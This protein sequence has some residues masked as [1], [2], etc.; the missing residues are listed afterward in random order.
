MSGVNDRMEKDDIFDHFRTEDVFTYWRRMESYIQMIAQAEGAKAY[1]FLQ[2]INMDLPE[3]DLAENLMFVH[4]L[5]QRGGWFCNEARDDDFYHNML[6]L[7]WHQEG[8]YLDCCH[9]S[10]EA[11]EMIAEHVYQVIKEAL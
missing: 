3:S 8:M 4:E 6:T 1:A 11:H 2:P 10:K 9:Y 5:N 7:F